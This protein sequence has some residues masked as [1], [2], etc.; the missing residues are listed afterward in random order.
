M[1]A[2]FFN[3][4]FLLQ[5]P[6]W[7]HFSLGTFSYTSRAGFSLFVFLFFFIF[8]YRGSVSYTSDTSFIFLW[9]VSITH[10]MLAS[11][12]C[13]CCCCCCHLGSF[14]Y[15][16]RASFIFISD[17]SLTHHMLAS[18]LTWGVSLTHPMASFLSGERLLNIPCW[19]QFHLGSFSYTSR[20][21]FFIFIW[22]VSLT[23]P[24]L[25]LFFFGEFLLHIPRAGFFF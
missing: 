21:G 11:F 1:L 18:F 19:L 9:R 16:S 5:I 6:C 7:F 2:L 17:V 25:V 15:T 4:E 3:G 12:C 23:R 10:P 13:C 22:G 8:F 14:S 20:A 24:M